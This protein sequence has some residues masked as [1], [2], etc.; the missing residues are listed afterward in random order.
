MTNK[1]NFKNIALILGVSVLDIGC[2]VYDRTVNNAGVLKSIEEFSST[3][4]NHISN[5]VLSQQWNQTNMQLSTTA[6]S[7]FSLWNILPIAIVGCGVMI[8]VM[9]AFAC[10]GGRS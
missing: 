9:G 2:G 8:V 4:S 5:P 7:S 6:A 1:I 3:L 10:D